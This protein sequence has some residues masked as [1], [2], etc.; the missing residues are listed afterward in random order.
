[1]YIELYEI[2]HPFHAT[3]NVPMGPIFENMDGREYVGF[4]YICL[5]DHKVTYFVY[6]PDMSPLLWSHRHPPSHVIREGSGGN[7]TPNGSEWVVSERAVAGG[8]I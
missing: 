7:H 4:C 2:Y 1:M 5:E 3:G 8:H 6:E